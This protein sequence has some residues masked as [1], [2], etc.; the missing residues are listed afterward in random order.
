[1][2]LCWFVRNYRLNLWRWSSLH[3]SRPLLTAH[4]RLPFVPA[5]IA[6]FRPAMPRKRLARQRSPAIPARSHRKPTWRQRCQHDVIR[7]RYRSILALAIL[8]KRLAR[9]NNRLTNGRIRS[10][11]R[12]AIQPIA[13][14]RRL[15]PARRTSLTGSSAIPSSPTV[16]ATSAIPA[17]TVIASTTITTPFTAARVIALILTRSSRRHSTRLRRLKLYSRLGIKLAHNILIRLG[18][19][20]RRINRWLAL[21]AYIGRRFLALRRSRALTRPA[22]T[23]PSTT[24]SPAAAA[25]GTRSAFAHIRT[26]SCIGKFNLP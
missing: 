10:L 25:I 17:A 7:L 3:K 2:L 4:T 19:S 8:P 22:P 26:V 20:L 9:K 6:V 5:F 18:L 23:T 21:F 11:I 12:A 24:T 16:A 1:V 14:T 15:K 13:S